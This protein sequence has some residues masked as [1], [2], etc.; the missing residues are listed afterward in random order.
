MT[1]AKQLAMLEVAYDLVQNVHHDLCRSK[2]LEL[3][4]EA[5]EIQRRL[6]VLSQDLTRRSDNG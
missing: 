5:L 1:K 3:A 4:E 2:Q 6:I